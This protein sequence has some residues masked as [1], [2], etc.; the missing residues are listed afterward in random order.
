MDMNGNRKTNLYTDIK[1]IIWKEWKKNVIQFGGFSNPGGLVPLIILLIGIG[2]F[3]PAQIGRTWIESPQSLIY[4]AWIP[5][6]LVINMIADSFAGEKERN[7]LETLLATCLTEKSIIL[8]K[9]FSSV[10]YVF[11]IKCLLLL[12]GLVTVNIIHANGEVV[13]YSLFD[14]ISIIFIGF[15]LTILVATVGAIFSLKANSVKQ[16]QQNLSIAVMLLLF[17]PIFGV[18]LIPDNL[19]NWLQELTASI[20]SAQIVVYICLL[21]IF[22]NIIVFWI[23]MKVFNRK[24]IDI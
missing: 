9:V 6:F 22:L 24:R 15:L 20:S 16:A 21:L 13:L 19:L 3:L 5:L 2:V 4:W 18:S 11:I 10:S 7:T 12:S 14:F 17:V 1:T 8:G 23:S